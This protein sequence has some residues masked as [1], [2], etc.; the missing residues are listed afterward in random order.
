MTKQHREQITELVRK[1]V[2]FPNTHPLV[3]DFFITYL[4]E[5]RAD[6]QIVAGISGAQGGGLRHSLKSATHYPLND[7]ERATYIKELEFRVDR[8]MEKR[9]SVPHEDPLTENNDP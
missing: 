1:I 7:A 4:M 9:R 8:Y 2:N 5:G 3:L 6:G